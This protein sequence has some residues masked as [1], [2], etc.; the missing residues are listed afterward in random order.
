M[1]VIAFYSFKGG[2]GRTMSLLS[3]AYTLAA[4]GRR[5]IVADWDLQAPGLSLMECMWPA[6]AGLP[7]AGILEYLTSLRPDQR[8]LPRVTASSLLARPRLIAEAQQRTNA[9]GQRWMKGD[10]FFVPAGNLGHGVEHFIDAVKQTE[11][12]NLKQ[13]LA[14]LD[15]D[16]R[17]V[18]KV[19]C[20]EIRT[21]SI[22]WEGEG[23]A[24]EPHY[25][26][27]DS[28]TGITE[29]GDLLLGDATDFNVIVYGQD[30]QNLEG[31]Q[32]VLNAS[33]RQPG[34]LV[35]NMMLIWSGAVAGQEEL[36]RDQRRRKQVLI[37]QVCRRDSLGLPEP[38]PREFLV[39]FNPELVY[40]NVPLVHRV[41]DSEFAES[42]QQ[43]TDYLEERCLWED[44]LVE[45]A[46][47]PVD[48]TGRES[49]E[50]R[51]MRIATTPAESK[52]RL[53]QHSL[54]NLE[55]AR[56]LTPLL[57]N[58][59]PWNLAAVPTPELVSKWPEG[60]D[61]QEQA[62]FTQLF[63]Y[64]ILSSAAEKRKILERAAGSSTFQIT[65]VL[66]ILSTE[67]R[68][69]LSVTPEQ[70]WPLIRRTLA[71]GLEWLVLLIQQSEPKHG[72]S[73]D[74]SK[75]AGARLRIPLDV[76]AAAE[77]VLHA[78]LEGRGVQAVDVSSQPLFPLLVAEAIRSTGEQPEAMLPKWLAAKKLD[79]AELRVNLTEQ[80][81][82]SATETGLHQHCQAHCWERHAD[83]L[84][85]RGRASDES[86]RAGWFDR[87][88]EAYERSLSLRPD[89][90]DTLNDLGTA[91]DDR[92][93]ASGESERA[94]WFDRAIEAYERSLSLRPD[95]A[96]TLTNLGNS[97]GKRGRASGESERAVWFDR[98]IEAYQRSLSQR[99]D[100]ADTLNNLGAAFADR[101]S[102]AGESERAVWFDRAIEAFERSLSLRPDHAD[103]LDHLTST[104]L[105]KWY[106]VTGCAAGGGSGRGG[107]ANRKGDVARRGWVALQLRMRAGV[108]GPCGSR[109]CGTENVGCSE[110]HYASTNRAGRG[111][112]VAGRTAGISG[113]HRLLKR[114]SVCDCL[115]QCRSGST[116]PRP[117]PL[118]L[119][120]FEGFFVSGAARAARFSDCNTGRLAPYRYKVSGIGPSPPVS[121]SNFTVAAVHVAGAV[122][123]G[124]LAIL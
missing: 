3:V 54:T 1:K 122:V 16:P 87:A 105:R 94:P 36:K 49:P 23:L 4:R 120:P 70:Y 103:T 76:S 77:A 60:I 112:C 59:P 104:L 80:S 71:A 39:P 117:M 10:L 8:E 43:I 67:R 119:G 81:C 34:D 6:D 99:P 12:H 118:T 93:R 68:Q 33:A 41:P 84:D 52:Q 17:M 98:A 101:G 109:S 40:S 48:P 75:S 124:V 26:L 95:D 20:E 15:T 83:A 102:A 74:D 30:F 51:R 5:V 90:A 86:E 50:Q 121:S 9:D 116:A 115:L 72:V 38:F 14:D 62:L 27:V 56:G 55:L 82:R 106:V 64:S 22:P 100:H 18:F 44:K 123:V 58:P 65:E 89:H 114:P 63:A 13:F 37:K 53:I 110:S 46:I 111:L 32:I 88:I 47:A 73:P 24:G 66:K 31:L 45:A 29:I 11:I 113:T 57:F 2:V 97:L 85:N 35:A 91:L 42:F 21:A 28:R 19:F 78:L 69:F 92:G 96:D 25:L 79:A 107:D 61:A 108:A 7:Q